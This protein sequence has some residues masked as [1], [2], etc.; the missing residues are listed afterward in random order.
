MENTEARC[1]GACL[2]SPAFQRQRQADLRKFKVSFIYIVSSRTAR[3]TCE[4]LWGFRWGEA[5]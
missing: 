3:A 5:P 1:N 2:E 4:I